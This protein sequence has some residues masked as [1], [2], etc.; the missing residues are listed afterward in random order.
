MS[1]NENK[2]IDLENPYSNESLNKTI[3]NY[4]Y[5]ELWTIQNPAIFSNNDV[6][7]S[8]NKCKA[9]EEAGVE[10]ELFFGKQP[11]QGSVQKDTIINDKKEIKQSILII[12]HIMSINI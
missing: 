5:N 6:N 4:N 12:N 11:I 9:F 8:N 7:N 1:K 10:K 3:Q 2:E